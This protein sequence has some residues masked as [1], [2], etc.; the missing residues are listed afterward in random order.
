M[1]QVRAIG[2]APIIRQFRTCKRISELFLTVLRG[3]NGVTNILVEQL[4]ECIAVKPHQETVIGFALR[5]TDSDSDFLKATFDFLSSGNHRI[6]VWFASP[7][8]LNLVDWFAVE[9][10]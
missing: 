6:A 7:L 9:C 1:R 4:R 8:S 5:I 3:I 10:V 2:N